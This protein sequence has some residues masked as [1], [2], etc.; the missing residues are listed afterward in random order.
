MKHELKCW[1]EYFQAVK[2][3]IKPFELRKD[4]R[5]YAV[6]DILHLREYD[7]ETEQYT[8]DEIDKIVTYILPTKLFGAIGEGAKYV[9][10]GIPAPVWTPCSKGLPTEDGEY[11][12]TYMYYGTPLV[13]KRTYRSGIWVRTKNVIAWMPSRNRPEPYNPDHIRDTTKKVGSNDV[14]KWPDWKKRAALGN[15]EVGKEE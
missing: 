7:P 14:S 13:D 4:D 8:G 11:L 5:G 10:M 6:G 15:Y 3:G 2:S 12:V 9:I 1:P